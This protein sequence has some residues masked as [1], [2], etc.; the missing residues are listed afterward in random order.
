MEKLPKYKR[1]DVS[2]HWVVDTRRVVSRAGRRQLRAHLD[3]RG[4]LHVAQTKCTN[5]PGSQQ[6]VPADKG[7]KQVLR[8]L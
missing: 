2:V 3:V 5:A 8:Q 6:D 4:R 1:L 7:A